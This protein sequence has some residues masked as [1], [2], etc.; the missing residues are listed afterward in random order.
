[1]CKT[2]H[3]SKWKRNLGGIFKYK[4]IVNK[5]FNWKCIQY[6]KENQIEKGIKKWKRILI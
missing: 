3:K 4:Q 2:K 6:L 5:A 1:M